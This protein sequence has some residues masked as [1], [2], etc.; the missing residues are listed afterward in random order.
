MAA[1]RVLVVDDEAVV[2]ALIVAFLEEAGYETQLV[3]DRCFAIA[4]ARVHEFDLVIT[5][6]VLGTGGDG[7]DVVEALRVSRPGLS[8]IF[9]SGYGAAHFGPDLNDPVLSKPFTAE[10]LLARVEHLLGASSGT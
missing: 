7:N 5:D 4:A 2:G 9:T 10:E 6:M 8:V 1:Q 3:A